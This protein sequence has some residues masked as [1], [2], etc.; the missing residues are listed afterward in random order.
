MRKKREILVRIDNQKDVQSLQTKSPAQILQ[1]IKKKT[2]LQ[3]A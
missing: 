2:L 1:E 3:R